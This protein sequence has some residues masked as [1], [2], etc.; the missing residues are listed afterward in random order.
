M[1]QGLKSPFSPQNIAI[2]VI[3]II[4]L[5]GSIG[6]NTTTFCKL[7]ETLTPINL[8]ITTFLVLAFHPFFKKNL[9]LFVATIALTGFAVEVVGVHTG[10][11][12]GA[13]YYEQNLGFKL[14]E[15][16]LIIGL[17]WVLLIYCCGMVAAKLPFKMGVAS[18]SAVG[19][20][21]MVL[22]DFFIEPFAIQHHL[23]QWQGGSIPIQNYVAWWVIAFF[24]LLFFYKMIKTSVNKVA[25]YTYYI[26]LVFFV[27]SFMLQ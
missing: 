9:L 23:W 12:F 17:N 8:L 24:M 21:L 16:P 27:L 7:F 6:L 19:A 2:S 18:K 22:I 1:Q 14:W 5:V 13:Y 11:I 4:H 25:V 3:T 10:S 26:M 20:N 15:V